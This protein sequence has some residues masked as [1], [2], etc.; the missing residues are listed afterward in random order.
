MSRLTAPSPAD[1][2]HIPHLPALPFVGHTLALLRDPYGL[3]RRCAEKLGPIYK[4]RMLGQ[5]RVALAGREACELILDDKEKQFS[6]HH[7]WDM[8][9]PIFGGGLMLRDFDD[10][11][12]HRRIMQSA[13]RKPVMDGYRSQ[14]D[15]LMPVLI[16]AWPVAQKFR[17]YPAIKDLSL[18]IGTSIFMGLSPDD[19]RV[20]TIN[21]AFMDEVNAGVG[22]I[23]KPLPFTALRRGLK[24]RAVLLDTFR[25]L[26]PERRLAPGNDFFSQMCVAQDES[27]GGWTEAEILD[28]FNFHMMAAHDTTASTI[29]AMVG[30]LASHPEWQTRLIGEIDSL[31]AGAIDDAGLAAMTLTDRVFREALRMMPPVPFIPRRATQDFVWKGTHIPA[32]TWVSCLPATVMMS[33]EHYSDP[34]VFDPDRFSPNRAEHHGARHVWAPFGGGAHKCIGMHFANLEV[35]IF[36]RHLLAR[37]RIEAVGKR[38][39]KWRRLPVPRP[40]GELPIRLIP[41]S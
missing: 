3:H 5:W 8:I 35:K 28:H 20:A 32:G 38:P 7:G 41:R 9:Q 34:E 2:A 17:F 11:R 23:R 18:R 19:P 12:R 39:V 27:G 22:V 33:P 24:A 25:A 6:A 31:P 37:Y 30:A 1:L 29:A 21:A 36:F 40:V 14:M 26:I 4:L 10:H 15:A 13:F 16:D